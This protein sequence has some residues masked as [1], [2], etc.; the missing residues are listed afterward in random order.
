MIATSTGNDRGDPI[1]EYEKSL[2]LQGGGTRPLDA[3]DSDEDLFKVRSNASAERPA[4]ELEA[5]DA[6]DTA[7][8]SMADLDLD[9][10]QDDGAMELLRDRFVTGESHWSRLGCACTCRSP[11]QYTHV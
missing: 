5:E 11:A 4:H 7:V 9:R 6:A 2:S 3:D 10:W 8:L 1:L